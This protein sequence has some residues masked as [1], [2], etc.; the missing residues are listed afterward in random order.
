MGITVAAT[1][2]AVNTATGNQ[3]FTTTALGGLT[4]K[5][6]YFVVTYATTDGTAANHAMLGI[7]AATGTA[8]RW[9]AAVS[10]EHAA[11]SSDT[12]CSGS[13]TTCVRIIS[14]IDGTV[15]GEADFVSF[16][17]NGVR[18]NWSNAPAA[19]Y[20]LTVVLFAGT[21]LSAHANNVALGDTLDNAVDVTA[22]GFRPDVVLTALIPTIVGE[23]CWGMVQED[24]AGT[25]SQRSYGFGARDAQNTMNV[26][27]MYRGD[28]GI[29][30]TS[31]GGGLDWYGE[32]GGFDANGFTV[33]TRTAGA[34]SLSL[35]YLALD[36]GSAASAWVGTHV[37]PTVT[38][39]HAVSTIGFEPQF[40]LIFPSMALADGGSLSNTGTARAHSSGVAALMAATQYCTTIS[41]LDDAGTSD[42]QSLS[43]DV[44]ISL[45]APNGTLDIEATLVSFDSGGYTLNFSNVATELKRWPVL[46]IEVSTASAT[47]TAAITLAVVSA[48]ATGTLALA[49]ASAATLGAVTLAA[50]GT[51]P[52][53]GISTVTLADVTLAATSTFGNEPI[54][55]TASITLAAV[56]S[57]AAGTLPING[58][59]AA[60]LADATL[61]ATGT[62]PIAASVNVT[63]SSATATATGTLPLVAASAATLEAATLVATG[64][65]T[66]AGTSVGSAAITLANATATAAGTLPIVGSTARTLANATVAAVGVLPVV[67]SVSVTFGNVTLA[68][69]GESTA[70]PSADGIAFITLSDA[71]LSSIGT[72]VILGAAAIALGALTLTAGSEPIQVEVGFIYGPSAGGTMYGASP[73]GSITGPGASGQI[74]GAKALSIVYGASVLATVEG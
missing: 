48:V 9:A 47:G 45:P 46:A 11:G 51:L 35:Y 31:I 25:V 26:W 38:G 49:A 68:A 32:F 43:D 50:T 14:P 73:F 23:M 62:L 12:Y 16:I 67:A 34:N 72:V 65:S 17:T 7:G 37:T 53:A 64:E 8:N 44:A 21:D 19:A 57:S 66:E 36:F 63:L 59:A 30:E 29:F 70:P 42:T 5:A 40:V 4:P 10:S 52:V 28:A 15:D 56:T 58:N 69:T 55:G 60:T 20:L 1:R 33:T 71:T 18:I 27:S 2:A 41:D 6:A 74:E 61:G 54:A 13:T 22:P 3:D 24:G 39:N